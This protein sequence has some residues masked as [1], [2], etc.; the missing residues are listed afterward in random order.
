MRLLQLLFLANQRRC[1]NRHQIYLDFSLKLNMSM[2]ERNQTGPEKETIR[3][4]K[5]TNQKKRHTMRLKAIVL[6]DRSALDLSANEHLTHT[7]MG[8]HCPPRQPAA[9]TCGGCRIA[10][11]ADGDVLFEGASAFCFAAAYDG[12]YEVRALGSTPL[13]HMV[14]VK[15]RLLVY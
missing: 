5:G 6:V 10:A 3:A 13:G 9:K 2:E 8:I 4:K 12:Y 7:S 15:S 11:S 14:V 1:H